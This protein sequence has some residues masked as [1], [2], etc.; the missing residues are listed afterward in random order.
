MSAREDSVPVFGSGA[1]GHGNQPTDPQAKSGE[2]GGRTIPGG[3]SGKP[4][5]DSTL[6]SNSTSDGPYDGYYDTCST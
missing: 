4:L 5:S 1:V 2:G 3:S 6:K